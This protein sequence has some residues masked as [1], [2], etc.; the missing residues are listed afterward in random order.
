M[1]NKF[2]KH[3]LKIPIKSFIESFKLIIKIIKKGLNFK[4]IS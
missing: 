1:I 2:L 3:L 4:P